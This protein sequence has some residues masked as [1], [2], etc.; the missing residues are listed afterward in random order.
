MALSAVIIFND[1]NHE[2][3]KA[4]YSTLEGISISNYSLMTGK[5][6]IVFKQYLFR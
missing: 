2:A 1:S 5:K 3:S 6:Q 4:A